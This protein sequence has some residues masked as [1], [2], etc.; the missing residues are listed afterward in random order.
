MR[1]IDGILYC[2]TG[3]WVESCTA[4][5][6]TADGALELLRMAPSRRPA[7]HAVPLA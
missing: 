5:V 6:E 3:D 2:N 1:D 4:L 7:A